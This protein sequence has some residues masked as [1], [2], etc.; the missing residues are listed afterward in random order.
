MADVPAAMH[1]SVTGPLAADAEG[2][3]EVDEFQ[4]TTA[5][6]TYALGDVVRTPHLTP[7]AIAAGRQLA[8]RL[9]GGQPNAKQDYR[10]VPTVVF[11]HPPIGAVGLTEEEAR[12]QHGD[13]QVKVYTSTVCAVKLRK[14][15]ARAR[16][17]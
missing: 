5:A 17:V 6:Y 7:V 4:N 16:T 10:D 15:S 14:M 1:A 8:N 13:A 12:Q 11:S 9:F 3:I 2:Y